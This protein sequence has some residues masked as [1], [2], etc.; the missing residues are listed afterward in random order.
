M[1]LAAGWRIMDGMH[2]GRPWRLGHRPGLDGL[3]AV[4]ILL[5]IASHAG[6]NERSGQVG[7]VVFFTLSGFLIA[8]LLLEEAD[9][10]GR[11]SVRGFYR[12]RALRLLPALVLM[13]ATVSALNALLPGLTQTRTQVGSLFYVANWTRLYDHSHIDALA[14]TWSLAIEEQFYLLAPVLVIVLRRRP[15]CL[16]AVCM[17]GAAV[18]LSERAAFVLTGHTVRAHLGTD[19]QIDAL[20]IGVALA[21]LMKTTWRPSAGAAWVPALGAA[22]VLAVLTQP[23]VSLRTFQIAGA[24]LTSLAAVALILVA[25]DHPGALRSGPLVWIGQRSYGI[26]LWHYPLL[27]L[28]LRSGVSWEIKAPIA[29]VLSIAIAAAS[30]RWVERPF[31]QMKNKGGQ[32]RAVH[33]PVRVDDVTTNATGPETCA[34]SADQPTSCP[35]MDAAV[36]LTE[37]EEK[38]AKAPSST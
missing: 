14:H 27:K 7:V 3:R 25:L 26:Y 33:S 9:R 28:A 1:Y 38:E 23:V 2:S 17:I 11:I 12:R 24:T 13:V 36:T 20:L 18:S 35:D 15:R 37:P 30:Y 22:A 16:A 19:T 6:L 21:A 34:G 8:T 4:A 10:T 5:V 31:L 32:P 29:V